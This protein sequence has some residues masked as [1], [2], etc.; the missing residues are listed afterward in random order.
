MHHAM[1]LNGTFCYPSYRKGPFSALT[2]VA[3]DS[4]IDSSYNEAKKKYTIDIKKYF[5]PEGRL[6]GRKMMNDLFPQVPADIFISHSHKDFVSAKTL[7]YWLNTYTKSSVF[8][9]EC[10]W[11]SADKLLINVNAIGGND[12]YDTFCKNASSVYMILANAISGMIHCC[13]TFIFIDSQNA[14]D[15]PENLETDSPW[16]FFEL[17]LIYRIIENEKMLL[18]KLNKTA[19]DNL[20]A[21][22][23]LNESRISL[24]VT[25]KNFCSCNQEDF[26]SWNNEQRETMPGMDGLY[27]FIRQRNQK[28]MKKS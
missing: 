28:K 13:H 10:F 20:S 16:I 5:T 23:M 7:A 17:Q 21:M 3:T 9:D 15:D 6:S 24:P 27:S 1:C 8:L 14:I 26:F 19:S 25:L 22:E 2:K 4:S 18:S 12:E 11:G